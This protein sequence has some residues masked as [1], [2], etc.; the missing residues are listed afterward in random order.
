MG[1]F[2]KYFNCHNCGYV[3]D[4][5]RIFGSMLWFSVTANLMVSF[6]FS[7]DRPLIQFL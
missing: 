4:R 7:F 2:W 5:I 6:I 1:R 3:Q